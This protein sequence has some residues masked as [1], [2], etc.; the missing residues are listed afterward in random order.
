MWPAW[1]YRRLKNR[2]L[3][4]I[5]LAVAALFLAFILVLGVPL[6]RDF[7]GGS[8]VMV[9]GRESVPDPSRVESLIEGSLGRNVDVM[10]V[11]NGFHIE[12]DALSE[13]E[14]TGLKVML[15]SEF[16]IP[17]S[18]VI[19]EP[20]GPVVSGLQI[21][22]MLYSLVITFVVIGAIT[23]IIFRRRSVPAAVILVIG[24]D[25]LCVL[26]FTALFR[27]PLGLTS[28]VAIAMLV[29]YAV[30]TN[31]ML[32]HRVLKR[33]GGEPRDHAVASMGTGLTTGVLSVVI[34][35]SLNLLTNY[36]ELSTLTATLIFGVAIN[37]LN[38]WFLGAGILLRQVER[39]RGKE[40]HVSL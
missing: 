33:A 12:T 39:Q 22:Q 37:I 1:H 7:K 30:D 23:L 34:F 10:P 11:E 36:T 18:S 35:L 9:Q 29:V 28:I 2:Q 25:I 31:I 14:E 38:T 15:S 8:L 32:A 27:V 21:E 40:Y 3:I 5:P 6:G 26:G 19:V 13:N 20:I 16:G 4:A 17:T 24:L